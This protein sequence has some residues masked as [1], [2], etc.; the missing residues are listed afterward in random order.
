MPDPA[1]VSISGVVPSTK[2]SGGML[3]L[4]YTQN[5]QSN[6][7]INGTG[8][9]D[10]QPI[11]IL[12]PTPP[13]SPTMK[14]TGTSTNSASDGSSTSVTLTQQLAN[15]GPGPL[16]LGKTANNGGLGDT[17]ANVSVTVGDINTNA[18][19]SNLTVSLGTAG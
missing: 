4:V 7:K 16:P 10:N 1:I 17:L 6:L 19:S 15:N 13:T 8:L 5:A 14:W 2:L 3:G 9:T 12:Y 11:L 18:V